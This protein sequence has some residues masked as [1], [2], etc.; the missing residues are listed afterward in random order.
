MFLRQV[1]VFARKLT[2]NTRNYASKSDCMRVAILGANGQIGQPLAMMLKNSNY[3]DELALYDV[4]STKSLGMEL[5]HIDTRCKVQ[6]YSKAQLDEALM[7][8]NIVVIVASAPH[9]SDLD[10]KCMFRPNAH[11]I[12]ELTTAFARICPRAFLAIATNPL[13]SIVPVSCDVLHRRRVF[14]ERRVFGITSVD[15]MRTNVAT[16]RIIGVKAEKVKVPVIG[17]HSDKTIVPVLSRCDP[18]ASFEP[19][20]ITDVTNYVQTAS[21]NL[22]KA[23]RPGT[24]SM[25]SAFAI[26]RFIISLARA[27]RNEP[28]IIECAYVRSNLYS[29]LKY[30]VTPLKLSPVG[31]ESNLG[32][33]P[34]SEYEECILQ[35]ASLLIK[36]DIQLGE[37]FCAGRGYKNPC[38]TQ[39][40]LFDQKKDSKHKDLTPCEQLE[41]CNPCT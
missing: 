36:Q 8:S 23:S 29:S 10:F 37:E 33:P 22:V 4:C 39:E 35:N 12:Y 41:V 21:E 32:I 27:L 30:L 6:S 34:L 20:E 14:D 31:I 17:G 7:N 9:A 1:C 28:N 5:A 15:V 18:S 2:F 26:A 25:C 16:A 40:L 38:E 3:V 11:I 24:L 19:D 13:N